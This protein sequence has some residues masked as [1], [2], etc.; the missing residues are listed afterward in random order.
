M[1][2]QNVPVGRFLPFLSID[3]CRSKSRVN[4]LD[5]AQN[6]AQISQI[7]YSSKG[8]IEPEKRGKLARLW[9]CGALASRYNTSL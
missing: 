1:I 4:L 9:R 2:R 3:R 6:S 5:W 8:A 7:F